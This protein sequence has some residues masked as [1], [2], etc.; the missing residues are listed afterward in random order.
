MKKWPTF[1]SLDMIYS[2]THIFFF[3]FFFA[4][5]FSGQIRIY[6]GV[7]TCD[8]FFVSLALAGAWLLFYDGLLTACFFVCL[9]V[10]FTSFVSLTGFSQNSFDAVFLVYK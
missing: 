7:K 4:D 3:F 8:I 5:R 2:K 9:F 6:L 10:C 1:L